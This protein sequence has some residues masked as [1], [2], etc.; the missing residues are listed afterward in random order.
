[1]VARG[2]CED[3]QDGKGEQDTRALLRGDA[4][5]DAGKNVTAGWGAAQAMPCRV[6]PL[7][8]QAHWACGPEIA[9][10]A[11]FCV[12]GPALMF[13][14]KHILSTLNF[15]FPIMLTLMGMGFTCLSAGLLCRLGM[16]DWAHRHT[17]SGAV[18]IRQ[19]VPIG[20]LAGGSVYFSNLA[21]LHLGVAYIQ[22]LKAATPAVVFGIGVVAGMEQPNARILAAV[23]TLVVGPLLSTIGESQVFL[24]GLLA[25][26]A[27]VLCESMKGLLQQHMLTDLHFGVVEGVMYLHAAASVFLLAAF[28]ALEYSSFQQVG[29]LEIIV[30]HRLV[31]MGACILSFAVNFV[32]FLVIRYTSALTLRVLTHIRN[33]GVVIV[34]AITLHEAISALQVFGFALSCMGTVIY[35]QARTSQPDQRSKSELSTKVLPQ[36][37][38]R[39]ANSARTRSGTLHVCFIVALC[40][41]MWT[42]W[43]LSD[44]YTVNYGIWRPAFWVDLMAW[45]LGGVCAI[46]CA[47]WSVVAAARRA[48]VAVSMHGVVWQFPMLMIC[49]GAVLWLSTQTPAILS[50]V[51][52]GHGTDYGLLSQVS[53]SIF[54][55]QV[56]HYSFTKDVY[57]QRRS[58]RS[59][60]Q[61]SERGEDKFQLEQ[62]VKNVCTNTA[63]RRLH[64]ELR[65]IVPTPTVSSDGIQLIAA[66]YTAVRHEGPNI[67]LWVDHHL[68]L[69]FDYVHLVLDASDND[70]NTNTKL[71]AQWGSRIRITK[72]GPNC[73]QGCAKKTLANQYAGTVGWLAWIDT[74]EFIYPTR[75]NGRATL[76]H[77]LS[78]LRSRGYCEVGMP[79]IAFGDSGHRT[80]PSSPLEAFVHTSAFKWPPYG[81]SITW[82]PALDPT[83]GFQHEGRIRKTIP[84][85]KSL[86]RGV[87]TTLVRG[88]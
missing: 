42:L 48:R 70:L 24:A 58:N 28:L 52:W 80:R 30:E 60:D 66:I 1:M 23:G 46:V 57:L 26:V 67:G 56:A 18:F 21:Y 2:Q 77:V 17:M 5:D 51:C 50:H 62:S 78:Q 54:P 11:L 63:M 31:F 16:A 68:R 15:Q 4:A 65:S 22:M 32:S 59:F 76:R 39:P 34:A 27:S 55:L 9:V 41:I 64:Q 49:I 88:T 20:L 8:V 43:N 14:N 82:M 84:F 73:S 19:V 12:V 75:W 81:K 3:Q 7:W 13:L 69:G 29:G 61:W 36:F 6:P 71:F 35:S 87:I 40:C 38:P 44:T 72:A 47:I 37:D 79:W 25:M 33:S 74:D 53:G 83:D 10:C 45:Y 86:T 85:C